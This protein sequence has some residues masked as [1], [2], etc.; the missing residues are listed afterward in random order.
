MANIVLGID[1]GSRN[2]GVAV[3]KKSGNKYEMIYCDVIRVG[4]IEKHTDRLVSIYNDISQLIERFSPDA[5]AVET[6]L[7]GKDPLALLKLGRAQASAML[8]AMNNGIS[9]DEYYPKMVKKSITGNG[10]ANKDQVAYMLD[11]VLA[12]NGAKFPPDATD[13]LAVAWCHMMRD[14]QPH[15]EVL[16]SSKKQHQNN[17]KS[18]W[19]QFVAENPDRTR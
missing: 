1:P 5:C 15:K 18:G 11:K 16:T 19:E 8:A 2:T 4:K 13:A 10:N 9:I 7:Y 3:L 17:S 14:N 6:P 12:L